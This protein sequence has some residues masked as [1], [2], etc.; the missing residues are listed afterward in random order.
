MYV[1]KN[2]RINKYIDK[3]TI[4][5]KYGFKNWPNSAYT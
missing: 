4:V 3:Y 2:R 5:F 1:H